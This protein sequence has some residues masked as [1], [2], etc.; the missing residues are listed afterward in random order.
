MRR[1][2]AAQQRQVEEQHERLAD[3]DG[4]AA[5]RRAQGR[6]GAGVDLRIDAARL[7]VAGAV[8]ADLGDAQQARAAVAAKATM[9]PGSSARREGD[10]AK[11]ARSRAAQAS[12]SQTSAICA[13]CSASST[14]GRS[15]TATRP[16]CPA[17]RRASST[18]AG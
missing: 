17:R 5:G 7:D 11:A 15:A 8:L 12:N 10:S 4:R 6:R 1:L 16:L 13:A 14:S 18:A 2:V 3:D 9:S